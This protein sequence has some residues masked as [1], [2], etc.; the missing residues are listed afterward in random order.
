MRYKLRKTV[1]IDQIKKWKDEYPEFTSTKQLVALDRDN[2]PFYIRPSHIKSAEWF[3]D[4]WEKEGS[5]EIHI[6]GLHYRILGMGYQFEIKE[7]TILYENTEQS[8]SYLSL[9]AKYARYEGLVPYEKILDEKN[10]D[11][12]QIAYFIEHNRFHPKYVKIYD[13]IS[14]L[15]IELGLS[16]GTT[17]EFINGKVRSIERQL[18]EYIEYRSDWEQPN[19]L[20]IWAEKSGVIPTDIVK[21]F[22][23][24]I[25][26]AGGGEFSI[27]MCYEAVIKALEKNKILH[28]FVL[29]DFDP[30]GRDMPKSIARKVEKIA[31]QFGVTAYVHFV[32]LTKEQCIKYSL[33]TVPAKKSKSKGYT[34]QT[35]IF[36]EYAGRD[37]TELNAFLAREPEEYKNTI[38]NAIS[39]YYDSKLQDKIDEE[40]KRLRESVRKKIKNKFDEIK[41]DLTDVR[42]KIEEELEELREIYNEAIMDSNIEDLTKEH[43]NLLDFD[44]KDI[45]KDEKFNMPDVNVEIPKDALLDTNRTYLEQIK[46]YKKFDIRVKKMR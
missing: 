12:K 18:F 30:K 36:K 11:P 24:T 28:V 39:P 14:G 29:S 31:N 41:D 19:Y 15:D 35:E 16:Y 10:P 3:A 21:D 1:D 23:I 27:R 26:P 40:L 8:Y 7:G 5:P 43:S 22:N 34:T 25:R 32:G 45:L 4:I 6:R 33:P 37:P 17:E 44:M 9:G 2:D 42:K 46:R 13:D 38:R 20:E